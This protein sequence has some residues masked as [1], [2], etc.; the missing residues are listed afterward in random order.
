MDPPIKYECALHSHVSVLIYER[1]SKCHVYEGLGRNE[2]NG[3]PL[4]VSQISIMIDS[5]QL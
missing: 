1:V 3:T 4:N 5:F 2:I